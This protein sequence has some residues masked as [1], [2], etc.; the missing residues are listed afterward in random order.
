VKYKEFHLRDWRGGYN[1]L[2]TP[3]SVPDNCMV[4]GSF[5]VDLYVDGAARTRKGYTKILTDAD[6]TTH[7]ETSDG[8]SETIGLHEYFDANNQRCLVRI[9]RA[10]ANSNT[11]GLFSSGDVCI[12]YNTGNFPGTVSATGWTL[13]QSTP[14]TADTLA[15]GASSGQWCTF[16]NYIGRLYVASPA[17]SEIKY[18]TYSSGFAAP[19]TVTD[20]SGA[21]G[22]I[23][24]PKGIAEWYGRIWAFMDES[25]GDG[26]YLHWTNLACD[27][28]QTDNYVLI[29]G[30]GPITGIARANRNLLVFKNDETFILSGGDDPVANLRVETVS[31]EVGCIARRSIV[32]VENG[33]YWM[34]RRGFF[35]FDGTGLSEISKPIRHEFDSIVIDQAEAI[36]GVRNLANDSVNWFVPYAYASG[37]GYSV[38]PL[39]GGPFDEYGEEYGAGGYFKRVLSYDFSAGAWNAPFTNQ[40]FSCSCTYQNDV[41]EGAVADEIVIAGMESANDN[42]LMHWYTGSTDDGDT[43]SG[44]VVSKPLDLGDPGMHKIVRKVYSQVGEIGSATVTIDL[45]DNYDTIETGVDTP[46]SSAVRVTSEGSDSDPKYIQS[47]HTV[48]LNSKHITISVT[49]AGPAILAGLVCLYSTKGRRS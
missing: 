46:A 42:H 41:D 36:H 1:S 4:S 18:L 49:M 24:K 20:N 29:P 47:R 9:A 31:N 45:Y 38:D 34:G 13:N 22:G 39:V 27:E 30:N 17:M 11:G 35:Y 33:V 26:S 16:V 8:V 19:T 21:T 6:A 7:A 12:E 32:N 15:T 40:D 3:E 5:D 37:L 10:T 25:V 48:G 23:N 43:V 2:S 14:G 44:T 28:F